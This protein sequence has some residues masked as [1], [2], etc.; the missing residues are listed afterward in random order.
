[1]KRLILF[2]FVFF[3]STILAQKSNTYEVYAIEFAKGS[4]Y[5]PAKEIA[6]NPT[7][8]DSVKGVFMTWLVKSNNGRTIL[9]DA[10]FHRESKFF[11]NW[12]MD[13]VRPDSSLHKMG[14]KPDDITDV[15]IT[16]PH[17][18]HI[19]GVDLFPKATIWMQKND[20]SY[21]VTDAWQ[22]GGNNVGFDS[23]DVPKIAD[24][25]AKGKI[26]LV[27]GDDVEIIPGIKVYIGSKHTYESQYVVVNTSTDKVLIASDNIW[28]YYNLNNMISIPLTFDPQAYV[29][30]MQRMKTLVNPDLIIP[31]HDSKI[32]KKFTKVKEG[33]VRI[34]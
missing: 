20:Y 24:L 19:G 8:N 5:W 3:S 28:F 29:K 33:V 6:I 10:G 21:F 16:H 12:L 14:L 17:W 30:A 27:N 34:R 26:Q 1:M 31:G 9:V 18:D 25:N 4:G 7:V 32:F 11:G 22:K 23:S 2:Y 13:F 15:I